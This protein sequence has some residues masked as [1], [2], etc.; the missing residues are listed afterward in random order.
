M[1]AGAAFFAVR[2]RRAYCDR[3][4]HAGNDVADRYT[5]L[6]RPPAGKIVALAGDAHQ[7]GHALDHEVVA[8]ALGVRPGLAEARHR[9]VDE[10]RVDLPQILVAQAVTREV[11]D[12]VVLHQHVALRGE[13]AHDVLPRGFRQIHRH[14]LLAAI[15]ASEVG[16]LGRVLSARV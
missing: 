10:P 13:L 11:A 14:R 4:V 15:G 8:G 5:R 1:L 16:G 6:L 7:S 2:E 12:F 3:R 9:A